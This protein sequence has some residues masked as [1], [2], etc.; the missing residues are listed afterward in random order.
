MQRGFGFGGFIEHAIGSENSGALLQNLSKDEKYMAQALL[1]AMKSNG[2][3]SP[4]PVVGCVLTDAEGNLLAEGATLAYGD[5][6]AETVAIGNLK[7]REKM[8]GGTAYVTLEPC[9]HYGNQPPCAEALLDLGIKKCFVA[10][11]DPNPKVNHKGIELLKNKGVEVR[12][13]LMREEAIAWNL[14]FFSGLKRTRPLVAAKWAQSLDGALADSTGKSQWISG[15]RARKYTHWLRAH[16]D[17]IMVGAGTVLADF[18]QLSAREIESVHRQPVK[19]IFDPEQQLAGLPADLQQKLLSSTLSGGQKIIWVTTS[20]AKAGAP[21]KS[22]NFYNLLVRSEA[23]L[24]DCLDLLSS[25]EVTNFLG[26]PI[27]SVFVEGGPTLL[28]G[29]LEQNLADVLHCY[30]SPFMLTGGKTIFN[31]KGKYPAVSL[32][33]AVRYKTMTV[34]QLDDDILVEL[35]PKDRFQDYFGGV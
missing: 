25:K 32:D 31:A 30:V 6:H 21:T 5:K 28:Q 13:G 18:P 9:S 17:A 24:E 14:A 4:N 34:H 33:S 35:V 2:L 1:A 16:Y 29:L 10:C 26:R 11:V 3:S 12:I 8:K 19:V 22:D 23:V 20:P 15:A 7:S 27:R